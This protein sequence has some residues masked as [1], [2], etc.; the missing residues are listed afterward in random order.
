MAVDLKTTWKSW[1]K[2]VEN[3]K[4]CLLEVDNLKNIS[5]GSGLWV[6]EVGCVGSG[7]RSVGW[8]GEGCN[9]DMGQQRRG[10]QC[11]LAHF[12]ALIAYSLSL[13]RC[14]CR[15]SSTH[16]LP[17]LCCRLTGSKIIV[18]CPALVAVDNGI[19]FSIGTDNG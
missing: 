1:P 7:L 17:L 19:S 15:G 14:H 12:R 5:N 6:E 4:R 10:E 13:S 2:L 18:A 8:W 16:L 9:S 3:S 11:L